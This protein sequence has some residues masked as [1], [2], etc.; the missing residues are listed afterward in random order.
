MTGQNQEPRPEGPPPMPGDSRPRFVWAEG[1]ADTGTA[2]CGIDASARVETGPGQDFRAPGS[3][4]LDGQ[5]LLEALAAGGFLDGKPDDQ[6][7]IMAEEMDAFAHGRMGAP[8]PAG[9]M[10]AMAVEHMVPGP[11][12]AQWLEAGAALADDLDENELAGMTIAARKLTSWAQANELTFV[13]RTTACAAAADP[14]IGLED[15][16]RPVRV[17]RDA[18]GQISLALTLTATAPRPGPT[19]RSTSRGGCP[20]PARRSRPGG[21]TWT[22][23]GR[24]PKPRPYST[25]RPPAPWRPRCCPVPARTP[26]PSCS[27]GCGAR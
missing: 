11:A 9:R 16:G 15:D 22:E 13:A 21:S 26:S 17:C 4:G 2:D 12:Q 18:L 8:L 14:K 19:W 3:G 7:A 23:P 10:A 27:G 1:S 24:S 25:T 20:T 6:D 5:V